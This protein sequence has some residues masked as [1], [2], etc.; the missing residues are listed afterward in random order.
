LNHENVKKSMPKEESSPLVMAIGHSTHTLEEFIHLLQVHGAACV[1]DVRTV[2]RSRHNPQFNQDSF[3]QSLKEAGL[4]YVHM[5]GLGGLRHAKSDSPNM[6]W[7]NASFRGFADYM[8]TPEF[9]Q[10][11]QE[12]I[13]LANQERIVLM[14]AEAVPWRCHRSLIADA[15][16]VRGIRTE[17]IMSATRRQVHTLTPFAKVRGFVITYPAEASESEQK[18]PS[19]KRSRPQPVAEITPKEG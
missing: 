1:V 14:C 13:L 16:L 7:R 15:L 4:G 17:D 5:P 18:K 9:A 19:A 11:L 8:Q 3:P 6:G 12:L 10:S 2:P